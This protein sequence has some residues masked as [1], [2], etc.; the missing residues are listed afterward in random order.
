MQQQK[1]PLNHRWILNVCYLVSISFIISCTSKVNKKIDTSKIHID[2]NTVHYYKDIYAIDTNNLEAGIDAVNAK[3]PLFSSVFFNELTGFNA[4]NSRD[5]FL[6]SVRHFLTYK[7]YK[8]LYD[9]VL[10]KFPNT[11]GID[12]DLK[13]LFE[14]IKYYYPEEK[15]GTVYYFISGLNQWS[16][17]TVDTLLGIGIDMHLGKEYKYYPSVGLPLYEIDKCEPEYIAINAAK[18]IFENKFPL[19]PEGKN[20]LDLMIQKGFQ[21]TFMEYTMPTV[22]DEMLMGYTPTQLKWC[23]E[24]ERMIWSYFKKQNL[25]YSTQWQQIMRYVNDGP[26]STGMPQESPGNIGTFIGWQLVRQY[27]RSHPEVKWNEL[28]NEKIDGQSFLSEAKYKP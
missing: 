18:T 4:N 5:T 17:I 25:L 1:Y 22:S 23:Q 28:I 27:L 2:F 24:N 26:T 15:W 3:Y 8:N 6:A 14:H 20:L 12:K 10:K 21:M 19:M 16:A 9:T 13:S 7:D 11:Q